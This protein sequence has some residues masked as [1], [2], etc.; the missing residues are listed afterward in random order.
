MTRRDY[1]A[2]VVVCCGVLAVAVAGCAQ[3]TPEAAPPGP[4]QQAALLK[5]SNPGT[6]DHFGEA[7]HTWLQQAM[8]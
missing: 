1:S 8:S 2:V 7:F 4:L 6:Y 5:A 3:A